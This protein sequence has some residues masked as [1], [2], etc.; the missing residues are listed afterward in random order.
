MAADGTGTKRLTSTGNEDE[1]SPTWSPEGDRIAFA[2]APSH[3]YVM[4]ANGSGARRISDVTGRG[5]RACMV[6]RRTT[7]SHTCGVRRHAD[8]GDLDHPART[9]L[10][11]AR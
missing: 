5:V 9:A 4:N 8:T 1:T 3:I 2:R 10:G 7:P 11:D 6:A